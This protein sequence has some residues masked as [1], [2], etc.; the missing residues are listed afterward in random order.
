MGCQNDWGYFR[1]SEE[2][3]AVFCVLGRVWVIGSGSWC[4]VGRVGLYQPEPAGA[5]W[6]ADAPINEAAALYGIVKTL[7]NGGRRAASGNQP[8]KKAMPWTE[9]TN[10]TQ[11]L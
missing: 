7:W 2:W 5:F 9:R 4:Y 8:P 11:H 6:P 1:A 3:A 10:T